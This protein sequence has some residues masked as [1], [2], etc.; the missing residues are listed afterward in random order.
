M[1]DREKQEGITENHTTARVSFFVVLKR[2][3]LQR[4]EASGLDKFF[5]L[6]ARLPTT[7]MHAFDAENRIQKFDSAE[8]IA[9]AYFPIRMSLYRDRKSLLESERNY[10]ATTLRNKARFIEAVTNGQIELT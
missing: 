7:N 1:R 10:S 6:R 9:D 8:S 2:A 3:Q 5:K 4:I